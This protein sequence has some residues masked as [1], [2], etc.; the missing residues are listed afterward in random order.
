MD[1]LELLKSDHDRVKSLF[2]QFKSTNGLQAQK[3]IFKSIRQE[4]EIHTYIEETIFYPA[5]RNFQD[6]QELLDDAYTEHKAVKEK[7]N[8]LV[9][10]IEGR[11]EIPTE[12]FTMRVSEIIDSVLEHVE[13]EEEELFP[14]VRKQMK[15]PEREQ[16]G[17]HLQAAK[18]EQREAA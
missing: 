2:E 3:H 17:R 12:E 10:D 1:A 13:M 8:A 16:M 11:T 5:F 4:L 15:R 7:L 9:S 6:F 18:D 14:M